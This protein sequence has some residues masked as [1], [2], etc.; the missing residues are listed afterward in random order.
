[1]KPAS[2]FSNYYTVRKEPVTAVADLTRQQLD[3]TPDN[4]PA[5]IDK[6][7]THIADGEC[8]R[9]GCEAL[10]KEVRPNFSRQGIEA[11]HV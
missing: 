1:M 5:S 8:F 3:R 11:S 10:Q 2:Y 7:L 4:H 6:L 9:I